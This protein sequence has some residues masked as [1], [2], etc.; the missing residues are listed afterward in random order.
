[1]LFHHF[2]PSSCLSFSLSSKVPFRYSSTVASKTVSS[3]D[4]P[5][6]LT[7]NFVDKFKN[8]PPPFGFNGLGELVYRRSYSRR[9]AN[10]LNEEW[11]KD[12]KLNILFSLPLVYLGGKLLKEL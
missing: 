10:G 9:L 4:E 6:H 12:T 11:Y 7:K 8:I 2:R 5:F 3:A 1:M